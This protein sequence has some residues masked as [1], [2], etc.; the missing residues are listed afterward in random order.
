MPHQGAVSRLLRQVH[1]VNRLQGSR[2]NCQ[3]PGHYNFPNK[4]SSFHVVRCSVGHRSTRKTRQKTAKRWSGGVVECWSAGVLECWSAAGPLSRLHGAFTTPPL[5]YSITPLL[6]YSITPS[7]HPFL[8]GVMGRLLYHS[9]QR[10]CYR[11]R[12]SSP[13]VAHR[14]KTLGRGAP[15]GSWQMLTREPFIRAYSHETTVPQP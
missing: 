10:D 12:S 15:V 9:C 13:I 5:H 4:V 14:I 7:L 8:T 2:P 3:S 1:S 11:N 6:H